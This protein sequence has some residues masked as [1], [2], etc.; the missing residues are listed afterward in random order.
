MTDHIVPHKG[1]QRLFWDKNN[2][3]PCC[4]WHHDV[5]KQALERAFEAGKVEA[6]D[7]VLTSAR[8]LALAALHR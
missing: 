8:A 2:W 4:A 5:V 3:Q 7:L 1:D 6:T